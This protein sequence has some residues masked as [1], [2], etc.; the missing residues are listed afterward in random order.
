MSPARCPAHSPVPSPAIPAAEPTGQSEGGG[1]SP[2]LAA[3]LPSDIEQLQIRIEAADT[4]L[5]RLQHL[6][7]IGS[8]IV[9]NTPGQWLGLD[10]LQW[11]FDL[12]RERI[13]WARETLITAEERETDAFNSAGRRLAAPQ[14][15]VEA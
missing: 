13:A 11:V 3:F 8:S 7:E 9:A 14:S 10:A 4:H 15:V 6:Y 1:S 5:M 12:Q 2:D